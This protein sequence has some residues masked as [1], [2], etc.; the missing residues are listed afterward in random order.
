A[1]ASGI[2]QIKTK[3]NK[4][5]TLG[6]ALYIP[7]LKALLLS[8]CCLQEAGLEVK[9]GKNEPTVLHQSEIILQGVANPKEYLVIV[10]TIEKGEEKVKNAREEYVKW[11]ERLG[12]PGETKMHYWANVLNKN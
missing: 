8:V 7:C 2:I 9:F 1:T 4:T 3:N 12:H 10:K 5:L 11:H 6:N